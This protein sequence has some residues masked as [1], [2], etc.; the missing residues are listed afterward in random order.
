MNSITVTGAEA[1]GDYSPVRKLNSAG[2]EIMK[3]N[4]FFAPSGE[5]AI[6][7]MKVLTGSNANA[8]KG[9]SE[10]ADIASGPNGVWSIIDQKR[11]KIYTYDR[12]GNLLYIFGD[13]GSQ[14]GNLTSP[15]SIAYQGSNIVVLDVSVG[16]FTVYRRTEY[17]ELLDE[18]IQLQN[19]REYD[20]AAE[21]WDEVLARNNYGGNKSGLF[22]DVIEVEGKVIEVLPGGKFKVELEN[23]C[24]VEIAISKL[25]LV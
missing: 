11:S 9:P 23:G 17:A 7:P 2:A 13:R 24:T 10:I 22:N 5:V 21:K 16:A 4:G 12:D 18:A 19:E 14:L 3:R 6:D 1:T 15:V 8:P 20:L 25:E